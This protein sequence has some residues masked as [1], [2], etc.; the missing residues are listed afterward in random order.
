[1]FRTITSPS[2]GA[3]SHKLYNALV[4]SSCTS[5]QQ[6]DSPASGASSHELYNVLVCSCY[7]A[8]LA[9]AGMY[10]QAT[11]RLACTNIPMRY[12]VYEMTLLMMDW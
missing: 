4:C 11:A 8:S 5:T 9:V 7:Q 12:T 1:M 6:L 10:I 3:L 2:L